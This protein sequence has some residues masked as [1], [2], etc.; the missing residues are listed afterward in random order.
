MQ[1]YIIDALM[2]GYCL[3]ETSRSNSDRVM[4]ITSDV[5]STPGSALL[6]LFWEVPRLSQAMP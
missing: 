6:N 3:H 4:L 2:L 1:G 5:L